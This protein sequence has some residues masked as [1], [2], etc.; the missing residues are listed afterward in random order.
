MNIGIYYGTYLAH[1]H[2]LL[3]NFTTSY[4]VMGFVQNQAHGS[5][6]PTAQIFL[7]DNSVTS[8]K[9]LFFLKE[10]LIHCWLFL[11][12]LWHII[13][14]SCWKVPCLSLVCIHLVPISFWI[15]FLNICFFS[16]TLPPFILDQMKKQEWYFIV[17]GY[18]NI[19]LKVYQFFSVPCYTKK[20][21]N[22]VILNYSVKIASLSGLYN[23]FTKSLLNSLFLPPTLATVSYLL[24]VSF[25]FLY[26]CKLNFLLQLVFFCITVL[27]SLL[28]CWINLF[29]NLS[30]GCMLNTL[31]F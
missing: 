29:L 12:G 4:V 1:P 23:H 19:T 26:N 15:T 28:M 16:P 30:L 31:G 24:K 22:K 6:H 10:Y 25:K 27:G 14:F 13:K 21:H 7:E 2:F 9:Y 11:I 18:N 3:P 17:R 8:D 20:N 5:E